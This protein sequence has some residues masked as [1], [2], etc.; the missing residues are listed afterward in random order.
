MP[1]INGAELC[2][3]LK[4]RR[5]KII[6][7]TGEADDKKAIELFNQESLIVISTKMLQIFSKNLFLN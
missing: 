4:E 2:H 6:L 3:R 5:F 1:K 7:L